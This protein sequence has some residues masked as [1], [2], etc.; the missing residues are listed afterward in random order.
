MKFAKSCDYNHFLLEELDKVE[1]NLGELE[2][3]EEELQ[4]IEH[5]EEIK[6]KLFECQ[7]L[8]ENSEYAINPALQLVNKN[9]SQVSAFAEHFEPLSDETSPSWFAFHFQS[10]LETKNR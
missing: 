5:A 1:L 2:T 10:S 7:E 4:I 3:L 6:S 8:L 9:I